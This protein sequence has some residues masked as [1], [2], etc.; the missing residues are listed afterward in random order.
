M[1]IRDSIKTLGLKLVAGRDFLPDEFLEFEAVNN[2]G[3]SVSIPATI[4][5]RVMADRLFPGEDPI[6][7]TFYSWGCLLYTSRCV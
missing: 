5:T 3:A 1:C 2:G 4:I 7:K 6:G